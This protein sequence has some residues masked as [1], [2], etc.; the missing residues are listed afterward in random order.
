MSGEAG[1]NG[2]APG[3]RKARDAGLVVARNELSHMSE[4]FAL[5][6][7]ESQARLIEWARREHDAAKQRAR[8]QIRRILDGDS[9]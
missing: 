8:E 5:P 1:E 3:A 4:I 6:P 9:E 2:T 7:E